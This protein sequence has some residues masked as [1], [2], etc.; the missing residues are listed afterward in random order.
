MA[1][2]KTFGE[3]RL[4]ARVYEALDGLT[5]VFSKDGAKIDRYIDRAESLR[6]S[7]TKCINAVVV[8]KRNGYLDFS[9][10]DVCGLPVTGNSTLAGIRKRDANDFAVVCDDGREISIDDIGITKLLQIY[11]GIREAYRSISRK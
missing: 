5:E 6:E 10:S 8:Q 1:Q 11:E 4:Q 3:Y 9:G 2:V 7:I